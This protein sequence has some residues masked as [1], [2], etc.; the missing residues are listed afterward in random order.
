MSQLIYGIFDQSLRYVEKII[1]EI[2]TIY[3]WLFFP[4]ALILN[5]NHHKSQAHR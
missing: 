4:H 5:K 1:L 3:L 2:S